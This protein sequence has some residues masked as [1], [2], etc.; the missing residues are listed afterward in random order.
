MALKRILVRGT[1][2]RHE[3]T[4]VAGITPG[5]LVEQVAAGVQVHASAAANAMPTFALE[6][7]MVGNDIDTAY[8]AADTVVLATCRTGDMINAL[9]PASA[10]AIVRGDVLQSNGD[11]TLVLAPADAAT[12]TAQRDAIV[13]YAEEAV[14]N[15]GGGSPARI[16][17]RIA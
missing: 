2:V 12:D 7:A 14:D 16:L 5:H 6:L 8:I 13:A 11:G 17:V 3:D 1:P 4:A 10:A 9:V 15:S